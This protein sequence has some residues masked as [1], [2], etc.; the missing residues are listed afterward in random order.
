MRQRYETDADLSNESDIIDAACVT[1][2]CQAIKLPISYRLDFALLRDEQ[3]VAFA[4]VKRRNVLHN[5]YP[6]AFISLSK[7]MAARLMR[8]LPS[9]WVVAWDDGV[10]YVRL[11]NH[12]GVITMG[13]RRDRHDSADIEPMAHFK[14]ELFKKL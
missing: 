11:D 1:W 13:G 6:T 4:E 7:I 14:T 3:V 9:F 10:G 12:D 2:Q 8:P 5:T